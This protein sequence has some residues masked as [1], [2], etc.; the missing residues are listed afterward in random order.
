MIPQDKD[1]IEKRIIK[2][3]LLLDVGS[4]LEKEALLNEAVKVIAELSK[5]I[6]VDKEVNSL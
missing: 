2:L 1:E 5:L 4:P 3:G 6:K